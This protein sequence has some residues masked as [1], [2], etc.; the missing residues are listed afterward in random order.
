MKKLIQLRQYQPSDIDEIAQLFYDTVHEVN[1]RDYTQQ[2]CDVWATGQVDIQQWNQAF[3]EHHTVIALLD[4][5]I[6]GFGDMDSTGYLDHLYVHKNAQR[7]GIATAICDLL[8]HDH[9]VLTTH[10]SITAKPFFLQRGYRVLFKQQVIRDGV[11][12]T[13]YVMEKK[14]EI[15]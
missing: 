8:E 14:G 15:L 11:E 10:A 3:L 9:Q 6:V 5:R 7:Q 13:N 4:H 2:Q 1:C 12:L